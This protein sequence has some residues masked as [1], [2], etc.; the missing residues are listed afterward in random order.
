MKDDVVLEQQI[1]ATL[2]KASEDGND[3]IAHV[4]SILPTKWMQS[5]NFKDFQMLLKSASNSINLDNN[6]SWLLLHCRLSKQILIQV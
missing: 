5:S 2:L 1:H 3:N 6:T 4:L